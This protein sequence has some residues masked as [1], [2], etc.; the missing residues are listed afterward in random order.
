MSIIYKLHNY[1]SNKFY[2][3]MSIFPEILHSLR[4]EMQPG[5]TLAYRASLKAADLFGMAKFL[6]YGI[7]MPPPETISNHLEQKIDLFYSRQNRKL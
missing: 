5:I 1:L 4:Q 6:F 7:P 2:E 3:E